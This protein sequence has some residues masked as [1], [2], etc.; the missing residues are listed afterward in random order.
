MKQ[1]LVLLALCFLPQLFAL[2][3]A[4]Q[5]GPTIVFSSIGPVSTIQLSGTASWTLGSDQQ[6][7]TVTLQAAATGQSR[8]DLQLTRGTW[9]ETQ[10]AATSF[11]G[12]CSWV[13]F[14]GVS[15]TAAT[16]NCWR[17]TVWFL[18]QL[19]LQAGTGWIDMAVSSVVN[20]DGSTDSHFSRRPNGT[21]SAD[22]AA[23]IAR[24]SGFDLKV[25][26]TGHPVAVKFNA[27]PDNDSS[28]D[29]PTEIRFSDYRTV[30]GVVVP[31]HIQKLI[32][33]G[34]VLDLQITAVQINQ[35]L[36]AA[37]TASLR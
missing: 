19:T 4:P 10:S 12:Q 27:H 8:M 36:A 11:E 31:F 2:Q 29:I 7:G 17:G 34:V 37:A 6:T 26:A 35:P 28:I 23:L 15:H 20:A 21:M 13:S 33:N 9:T 5:T 22:T 14:D 18:P 25:D 24:F 32:N 1:L 3:T 16:H 30:N